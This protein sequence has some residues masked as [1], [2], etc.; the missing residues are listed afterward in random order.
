M[1]PLLHRVLPVPAVKISRL[2]R[3]EV[4]IATAVPEEAPVEEEAS[5]LTARPSGRRSYSSAK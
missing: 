1:G 3:P 5:T 4:N 2:Q